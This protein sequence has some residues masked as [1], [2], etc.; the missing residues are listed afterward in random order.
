MIYC[1]DVNL[2]KS[3]TLFLQSEVSEIKSLLAKIK[4]DKCLFFNQYL[5]A[6]F[7]SEATSHHILKAEK[8]SR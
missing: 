2:I 1:I 8:V 7:L 4:R 5:K 6:S 3:K